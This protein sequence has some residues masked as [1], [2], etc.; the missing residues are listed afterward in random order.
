MSTIFNG[1]SRYSSDFQQIIDRAVSIA[2]LPLTQ[3][4]SQKTTLSDQSSALSGLDTALGSLQNA[5]GSLNTATTAYSSSVSDGSVARASVTSAAGAGTYS[6]EVVDLGSYTLA[7]SADGLDAVSDPSTENISSASTF[8]LTVDGT[9]YSITP[10]TNTL[11]AMVDA[12]NSSGAAVQATAV[13]LGSSSAPDY[14]LSLQ[15]TKLG[16]VTVELEA[17]SQSLLGTP[18]TGTLATYR[19]NGQP[20]VAIET[21]SRNVIVAPGL[22]VTLLETGTAEV[23]VSHDTQS[24]SSALAALAS[25]YNKV[26][27]EVDKNRGEDAGAL[28]GSSILYLVSQS[29][30][31]MVGYS[32]GV[33][34]ISSLTSLGLN[35]DDSGKLSLDASAFTSATD[36]QFAALASFLGTSSTDG[37]LKNA[38]DLI[39]GLEDS[40]DGA[41]KTAIDSLQSQM[42]QQD[43]RIAEEQDR[44]D[45]LTEN[46]QA[47]M[48]AADA[49]IAELEQ[50]VTYFTGLFDAMKAYQGN[51]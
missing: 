23:T 8:T 51:Q 43:D 15:S 16:E 33:D 41:V 11:T 14:R 18:D 44:I 5:I 31:D 48:S 45:L 12:I 40:S 21:D 39:D 27:D 4:Q 34:G 3:L 26:V 1:T 32:T 38:A 42:T 6:I 47:Q 36:G 35:F 13:N 30:R 17:E 7:M 25:A 19:V 28:Q 2:S 22:T 10:E 24:V 9:E 46:L 50:Q 37:F 29:L 49:L 20:A